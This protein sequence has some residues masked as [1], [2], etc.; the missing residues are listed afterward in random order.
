[1]CAVVA[2]SCGGA[3][4][5]PSPVASPQASEIV[6]PTARASAG[7]NGSPAPSPTNL[8][9]GRIEK[10]TFKSSVLNRTM[11]FVVYLPPG[12]DA[13]PTRRYPTT[14]LLHGGGGDIMEWPSYGAVDMADKLMGDQTVAPYIIVFPEGDQEY[15]VDHVVDRAT[16]ANGEKW[17]TYTAREV[18]P[19]IDSRY[20]TIAKPDARAIGGLSMGGHGA[21][22]LAMNF[23]GIWS[24]VGAHSPSLRPEGD[25]PTYLGFGDEFAARD[26]LALIKAKP[27]I[28]RAYTWWLDTGS[29]DPWKRQTEQIHLQLDAFAIPHEWR[30]TTGDHDL[31]YWS[32]HMDDYIKYY[33]VALCKGRTTC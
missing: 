28:A 24:A 22:Q 17:G 13:N 14:Y 33:G 18:V 23:P 6:I 31:A 30:L 32:A 21:M 1:L 9:K 16:G 7:E 11:Q 10:G 15:W 25:A 2:A 27:E 29:R 8:G 5:R 19:A 20:R 3:A 4:A 12:Y 26:P